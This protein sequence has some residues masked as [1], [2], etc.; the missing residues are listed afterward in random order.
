[1]KERTGLKTEGHEEFI[2][3]HRLVKIF[4]LMTYFYNDI[5]S[6]CLFNDFFWDSPVTTQ[7]SGSPAVEI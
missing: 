7:I 6:L 1:M 3:N 4:F 5:K 2:S